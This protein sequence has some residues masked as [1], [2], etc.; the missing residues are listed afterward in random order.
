MAVNSTRVF[1]K[2]LNAQDFLLT[3]NMGLRSVSFVLI[4]GVGTF[5][6][7]LDVQGNISTPL[8]LTIGQ[9]VTISVEGNQILDGIEILGSGGVIHIIAK[10]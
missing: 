9:A 4:S 1:T 7:Q 8:P 3:A 10:H 2:L 6:G 5:K